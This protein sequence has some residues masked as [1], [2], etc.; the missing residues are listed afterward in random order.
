M[1]PGDSPSPELLDG[2]T[3]LDFHPKEFVPPNED[4]TPEYL[5]PGTII[6]LLAATRKVHRFIN[7]DDDKCILIYTDGV[8]VD[9]QGQDPRF[10][11]SFVYKDDA[12]V[13]RALGE[14]NFIDADYR[15]YVSFAL[16]KA[17]PLGEVHVP[18][19][20]RAKL[21]AV[22]AALQ[23]RDWSSEG[24]NKLVIATDS[25][26][27]VEGITTRVHAWA[28]QD[29][30]TSDGYLVDSYDLWDCLLQEIELACNQNTGGLEVEFWHM[31]AFRNTEANRRAK[32]A[33]D[34]K[35]PRDKFTPITGA[36]V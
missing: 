9:N 19:E 5:F 28:Q 33:A 25:D 18:S 22:I 15:N 12:R 24:F 23:F 3:P 11:C 31:P 7:R 1:R 13:A 8:R 26:Y 14:T 32:S 35:E 2:P 6:P 30:V 29:W 16:E 36:I 20:P 10:G 34:E 17:G 4:D 21:R 27:V